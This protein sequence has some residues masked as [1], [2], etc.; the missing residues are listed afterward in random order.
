[1]NIEAKVV[2]LVKK[3]NSEIQIELSDGSLDKDLS[4]MNFDSLDLF[5]LL[6]EIEAEFEVVVSDDQVGSI[7]SLRDLVSILRDS[8]CEI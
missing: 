1:M 6:S 8:G 3:V 4:E 5:Y 2:N 7:K